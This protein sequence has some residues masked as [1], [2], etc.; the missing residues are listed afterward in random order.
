MYAD[1]RLASEGTCQSVIGHQLHH[2]VQLP[3]IENG[4][5]RISVSSRNSANLSR[6]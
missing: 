1:V 5:Q 6:P 2:P 3:R 4:G